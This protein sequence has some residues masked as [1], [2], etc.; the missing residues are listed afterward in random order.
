MKDQRLAIKTIKSHGFHFPSFSRIVKSNE[1]LHLLQEQQH[2]GHYL[3]W[4]A[5][6]WRCCCLLPV[7]VLVVCSLIDDVVILCSVFRRR[8]CFSH[9]WLVTPVYL[10]RLSQVTNFTNFCVFASVCMLYC[11]IWL[12]LWRIGLWFGE[13]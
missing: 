10:D 13:I 2:N 11:C 9:L 8:R 6:C 3:C 7:E 12:L 5:T 4:G 1:T